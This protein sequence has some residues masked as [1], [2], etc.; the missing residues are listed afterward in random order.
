MEPF[1]SETVYSNPFWH[2]SASICELIAKGLVVKIFPPTGCVNLQAVC[3][4]TCDPTEAAV[5]DCTAPLRKSET[6]AAAPM[7]EMRT[8]AAIIEV[9]LCRALPRSCIRLSYRAG[10]ALKLRVCGTVETRAVF[11]Y[12]WPVIR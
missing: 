4:V 8:S 7:V 2:F 1:I 9:P 11:S 10:G 6:A 5:W 3:F 12:Q